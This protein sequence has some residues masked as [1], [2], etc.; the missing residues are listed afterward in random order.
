MSSNPRMQRSAPTRG[1]AA[2]EAAEVPSCS[3]LALRH[4]LE[5]HAQHSQSSFPITCSWSGQ[6]QEV[7]PCPCVPS[8]IS[9]LGGIFHYLPLMVP[10]ITLLFYM[11]TLTMLEATTDP[12]RICLG[13]HSHRGGGGV[14][15]PG[16]L[17]GR[18]T[19]HAVHPALELEGPVHAL[20][21]HRHAGV[22]D[23]PSLPPRKLH[24]LHQAPPSVLKPREQLVVYIHQGKSGLVHTS[25]LELQHSCADVLGALRK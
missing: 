24:N 13:Q 2:T 3:L 9:T 4:A 10:D 1:S 22:L 5:E 6:A 12:H 8:S 11:A 20:P 15:A 18:H 7:M 21:R 19:L 23:P 16:R 17:G 25:C 14:H